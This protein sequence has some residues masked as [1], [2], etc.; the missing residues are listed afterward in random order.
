MNT[1]ELI[2]I[3]FV[4]LASL[5]TQLP[6]VLFRQHPK[7]SGKEL[8]EKFPELAWIRFS[9]PILTILWFIVFGM[10]PIF[11]LFSSD[12][13]QMIPFQATVYFLGAAIGSLSIL[14]GGLALVTNVCPIPQRRNRQYVYDEDMQPTALLIMAVGVFVISVALSMIIFF[15]M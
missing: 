8:A 6:Q 1:K 7:L 3:G 12:F 2:G 13:M 14:N 9:Y 11:L 4:V 10:V 5:T 15:V